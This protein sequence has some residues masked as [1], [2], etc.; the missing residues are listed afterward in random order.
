M[1]QSRKLLPNLQ[2]DLPR[3]PYN[4]VD[5]EDIFWLRTKQGLLRCD[6]RFNTAEEWSPP[7]DVELRDILRS[8][9]E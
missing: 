6:A 1:S 8:W 4:A 2:E 7:E 3:L 9:F 5:G